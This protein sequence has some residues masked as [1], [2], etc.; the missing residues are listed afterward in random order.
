MALVGCIRKDDIKDD[1]N[2]CE[3]AYCNDMIIVMMLTVVSIGGGKPGIFSP[4]GFFLENIKI[5]KR[6]K[7]Y[8]Y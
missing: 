7:Y 3:D 4:P 6:R 1:K 8:K 5:G 2:Y